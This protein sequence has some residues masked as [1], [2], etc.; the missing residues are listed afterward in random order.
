MGDPAE[1]DAGM[2]VNIHVL[3]ERV[4]SL[5]AFLQEQAAPS[6]APR[7]E[8]GSKILHLLSEDSKCLPLTFFS[9]GLKL[10]DHAFLTYGVRPAQD[11]IKNIL[12]GQFPHALQSEYPQGVALKV[13]DRT[14]F[15]FH[16]WLRNSACDDPD[17]TDGG[18]A[19]RPSAGRAVGKDRRS[20]GDRLLAKLPE[21]VVKRGQICN[22]RGAIAKQLNIDSSARVADAAAAA[23]GRNGDEVVLLDANRDVAATS[24]KLQV[25]LEGGHRVQLHMEPHATIK[26]LWDALARW[27]VKNG[28][29]PMSKDGKSYCLRTAFP[30]RSYT[31]L[32]ATLEAAGLT[33]SATLFV[34]CD[35][36][37]G[38]GI[39]T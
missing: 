39:H 26:E 38:T 14:S 24:A 37:T 11:V 27:R 30:P 12:D 9:D 17:L 28:L 2:L 21:Q 34:S 36:T 32:T 20:A 6:P 33:P 3:R 25:K 15:S 23:K 18:D 31:D 22:I 19:L 35:V 29:P 5:N 8:G 4:E 1:S 10:A 16:A 13:V 7:A